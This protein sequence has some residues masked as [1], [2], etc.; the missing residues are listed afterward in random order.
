MNERKFA[1]T[2]LLILFFN[3]Q[4]PR[5]ANTESA[6]YRGTSNYSNSHTFQKHDSSE[7]HQK[8]LEA[9]LVQT[10]PKKALLN[11]IVTRLT[12]Q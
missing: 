1:I 3:F 12:K 9:S 4:W 8:C 2:L 10:E 5:I 7:K 6:F 11:A